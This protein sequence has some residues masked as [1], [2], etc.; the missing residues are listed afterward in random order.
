M[1]ASELHS[2]TP[3]LTLFNAVEH[4]M[5]T[6]E[7]SWSTSTR[8]KTVMAGGPWEWRPKTWDKGSMVLEEGDE[9]R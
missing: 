9:N 5:D 2:T 3:L 8:P 7:F 6:D 4:G 1:L